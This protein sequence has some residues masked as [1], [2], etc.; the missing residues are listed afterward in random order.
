MKTM[1]FAKT[2]Q[3]RKKVCVYPET[4]QNGLPVQDYLTIL[5]RLRK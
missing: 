5:K 1:K 4:K 3:E 2:H